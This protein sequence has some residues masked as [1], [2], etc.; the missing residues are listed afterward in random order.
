MKRRPTASGPLIDWPV[1]VRRCAHGQNEPRCFTRVNKCL[2]RPS[3]KKTEGE[4]GAAP[5]LPAVAP[6]DWQDRSGWINSQNSHMIIRAA[7]CWILTPVWISGFFFPVDVSPCLLR[8]PSCRDSHILQVYVH[9]ETLNIKL[10]FCA[11]GEGEVVVEALKN[12]VNGE[13]YIH[14]VFLKVFIWRREKNRLSP[15][16]PLLE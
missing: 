10:A 9:F 8:R 3:G 16:R 2:L 14:S 6:L 11:K 5:V 7:P 15:L 12:E 1:R 13:R 4:T